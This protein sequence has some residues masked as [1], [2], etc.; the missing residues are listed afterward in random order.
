[1]KNTIETS[2]RKIQGNL[3]GVQ[4]AMATACDLHIQKTCSRIINYSSMEWISL[5]TQHNSE[6]RILM[7][8]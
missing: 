6:I 3:F 2:S 8:Q 1:M 7:G 5:T 4:E